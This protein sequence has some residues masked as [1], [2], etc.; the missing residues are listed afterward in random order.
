MGKKRDVMND[1]DG[2]AAKPQ[3]G[4]VARREKDIHG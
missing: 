1:Q 3:R 2:R 4:G